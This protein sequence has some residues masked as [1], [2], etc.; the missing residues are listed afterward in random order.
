ME[1]IQ[2]ILTMV[3]A[4]LWFGSRW[5]DF[6]ELN[7]LGMSWFSLLIWGPISTIVQMF[8]RGRSA[9]YDGV[10]PHSC[11]LQVNV[12]VHRFRCHNPG[13]HHQL[14]DPLLICMCRYNSL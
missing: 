14:T 8:P 7:T 4:F 2:T 11:G 12:T 3:D 6:E 1:V 9:Q 13:F 10:N 5:G